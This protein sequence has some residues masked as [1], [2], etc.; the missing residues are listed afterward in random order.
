MKGTSGKII[1]FYSYKGGTGRSMA[2]SN[3]AWIL[4]SNG[5]DVLLIDWDLEAPGLH[6]YLRP[7]LVDPELTSSPGVI[8]FVWEAARVNVTPAG[9]PHEESLAAEFSPPPEDFPS[10]EDYVIG[11]NWDFRDKGSI[12]FIPAGRQDENYAQRVNTFSWDNFYERL[13]GGKLLQSEIDALRKSYDYILIDS[14]T[15]VS[16]TSGI[17]T[18]QLPDMLAVFFT[19]NL[20]SIK[21]AAAVASSVRAQL[22]TSFPIFPVPSRLENGEQA[23]LKSATDFARRTFAPFLL[24]VQSDRSEVVLNEQAEYWHEVETPY[25][26]FY[27]F[28]EVP[29]AFMEE[30]GSLRGVLAP[31]ER[32]A[33][34]LSDKRVTALNPET[35]ELRRRVVAAYNFEEDGKLAASEDDTAPRSSVRSLIGAARDRLARFVERRL[36]Q[37]AT[38]VA[39]LATVFLIVVLWN[40]RAVDSSRSAALSLEFSRSQQT[41]SRL[42]EQVNQTM[43]LV[44]YRSG[45]K[46]PPNADD[47]TKAYG[48]LRA[49]DEGL[50]SLQATAHDLQQRVRIRQLQQSQ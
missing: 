15:G 46:S 29:A 44:E 41:L 4:A 49:I 26:S 8:D 10:L 45:T 38:A 19:L 18:V 13:G 35:D 36:W 43:R 50:T 6:R 47:L 31:M 42:S 20:Q 28:E 27:A 23:K 7:F 5:C 9:K 21:G 33:A 3:V 1:T 48:N 16:D 32:L 11:F 24:H 40:Q 34:R 14:R 12:S 22:G 25:I 37:S 30:R 2:V 39:S 17:C